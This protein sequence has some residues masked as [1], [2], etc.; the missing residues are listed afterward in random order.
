MEDSEEILG[1][2]CTL[3]STNEKAS[4]DELQREKT[5]LRELIGDR[6]KSQNIR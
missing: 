6:K 3:M 2:N 4:K 1:D 5:E